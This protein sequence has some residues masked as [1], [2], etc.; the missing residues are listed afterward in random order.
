MQIKR[1]CKAT[2]INNNLSIYLYKFQKLVELLVQNWN[3]LAPYFK[4]LDYVF[5]EYSIYCMTIYL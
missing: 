2:T 4:R 3:Q 1:R 5:E